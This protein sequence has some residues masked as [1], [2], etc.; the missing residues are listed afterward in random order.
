MPATVGGALLSGSAHAGIDA[1]LA[2]WDAVAAGSAD[3]ALVIASDAVIPGL[4][5]SV[6]ARTGAGAVAFVL[7][8]EGGAAALVQRTT[9]TRPVLDRYRGDGEQALRDIYDG[10]LFREEIYLPE[11]TTVAGALDGEAAS[12]SLPDPDGRLAAAAAR[13]IGGQLASAEAYAALGDCGAAAA[14]LGAI[15]ALAVP[16]RVHVIAMGGGRTTGVAI[17]AD[18]AVAG[19]T[20][21]VAAITAVGRP[22]SYAEVLRARGQLVPSGET[23]AMAVPPGSAQ[24]VRGAEELLGLLGARCVDCGVVSTP[25]SIHPTCV[26]C[27]GSKLEPTALAR[28]G[29]VHTFV[30]NQTMPAPFVAPLPLVVAD[31]EDGARIMLQGIADD[32][33]DFAIGD[34]VE[35]V[36]RKYAHE[37]GVPV[38][39]YKVQRSE[40]QS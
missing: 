23:V 37:R 28:R 16:G 17:D 12:W 11:V 10:R 6:E 15:A 33:T 18:A 19:A 9:R 31:L 21:A 27:G 5:T 8:A 13:K 39:G 25:P 22:A 24:F 2:A 36:L 14:L 26:G 20:D 3:I 29:T 40:G 30:V 34:R 35:L 32:A 4:G 7:A 38:Y 1:L